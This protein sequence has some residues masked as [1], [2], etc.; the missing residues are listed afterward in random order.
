[1]GSA[2][3]LLTTGKN[4]P[5]TNFKKPTDSGILNPETAK[6]KDGVTMLIF[7]PCARNSKYFFLVVHKMFK[8]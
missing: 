6:K 8:T 5:L 3:S 2:H 4:K 7:T 1:M